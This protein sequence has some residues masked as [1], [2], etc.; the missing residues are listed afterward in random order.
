MDETSVRQFFCADNN[1]EFVYAQD[2]GG[3]RGNYEKTDQ[4]DIMSIVT[5]GYNK[6]IV[7]ASVVKLIPLGIK[8]IYMVKAQCIYEM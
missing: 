3:W 8:D 4:R 2:L 6:L 1:T 7:Y 5:T